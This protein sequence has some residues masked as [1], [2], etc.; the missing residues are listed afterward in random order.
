MGV[1]QRAAPR[2]WRNPVRGLWHAGNVDRARVR[3][4][5]RPCQLGLPR[6]AH[7]LRWLPPSAKTRAAPGN[8]P[9]LLH[10]LD[11]VQTG[12][13]AGGAPGLLTAR[14]NSG[15]ELAEGAPALPATIPCFR[16]I[17]PP[18]VSHPA[19]RCRTTIPLWRC[20]PAPSA[21]L[22]TSAG[23][24]RLDLPSP[25]PGWLRTRP[26]DCMSPAADSRRPA[27]CPA[28]WPRPGPR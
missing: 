2:L 8:V 6:E 26:G 4:Y 22:V 9:P 28:A 16:H 23:W 18:P 27:L 1:T 12:A 21:T 17:G 13:S 15:L 24:G 25:S 3:S 11:H 19:T 14:R 7:G 10:K 20:R 5:V